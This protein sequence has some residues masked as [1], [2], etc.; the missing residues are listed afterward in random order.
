[1]SFD[2]TGGVTCQ[3]KCHQKI[4]DEK[5]TITAVFH[6]NLPY[7]SLKTDIYRFGTTFTGGPV[8]WENQQKFSS[9]EIRSGTRCKKSFDDILSEFRVMMLSRVGSFKK[10][11]T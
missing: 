6:K 11:A 5:L 2:T 4:S 9:F 8:N 3:N 10:T 1:M 7:D